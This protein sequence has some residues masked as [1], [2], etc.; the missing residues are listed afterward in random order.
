MFSN[1][2]NT[3]IPVATIIFND[4]A[5]TSNDWSRDIAAGRVK[6]AGLDGWGYMPKRERFLST[7]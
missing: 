2:L 7:L 4:A 1:A 3:Y 5:S 6:G